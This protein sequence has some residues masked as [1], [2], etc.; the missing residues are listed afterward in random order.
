MPRHTSRPNQCPGHWRVHASGV[1]RGRQHLPQPGA[2]AAVEAIP[3]TAALETRELAASPWVGLHYE[4]EN[5][6]TEET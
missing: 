2:A 4:T 6:A 3:A 5:Y 1:P